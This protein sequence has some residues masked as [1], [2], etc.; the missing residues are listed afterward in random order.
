MLKK[1]FIKLFKKEYKKYTKLLETAKK[2]QEAIIENDVKKLSS[3]LSDEQQL[4]DGIEKLEENRI[5]LLKKI[6]D[7]N[8]INNNEQ[9]SFNKLVDLFS[10]KEKKELRKAK[11]NLMNI[12]SELE[13]INEENKQLIEDSLLINAQNFEMIRN[14]VKK[15]NTYSK[16]GKKSEDGDHY[17]DRKV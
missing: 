10:D 12:L 16:P 8:D 5:E 2:K 9:I 15:D 6:A 3:V 14:A 7:K 11:D 17:I 13:E 4:L 1:K